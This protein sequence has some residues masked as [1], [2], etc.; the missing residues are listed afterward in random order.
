MKDN[1]KKIKQRMT[2]DYLNNIFDRPDVMDLVRKNI[3][4]T[5]EIL[6]VISNDIKNSGF[7]VDG[8]DRITYTQRLIRISY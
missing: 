3:A 6:K 5:R 4:E 8:Q 7:Y 2:D 1:F